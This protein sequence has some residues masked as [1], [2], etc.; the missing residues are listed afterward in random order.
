MKKTSLL[1]AISALLYGTSNVYALEIDD[2]L[3]DDQILE[4]IDKLPDVP[5]STEPQ[6]AED[7]GITGSVAGTQGLDPAQPPLL[8][9]VAVDSSN[10]VYKPMM[11]PDTSSFQVNGNTMAEFPVTVNGGPTV[12]WKAIAST[13]GGKAKYLVAVGK[14]WILVQKDDTWYK[15]NPWRLFTTV[16]ITSIVLKPLLRKT[17]NDPVGQ[18]RV[19]AFDVGG[20]RPTGGSVTGLEHT[21]GAARGQFIIRSDSSPKVAFTATYTDPV[22]VGHTLADDSSPAT[23]LA[24]LTIPLNAKADESNNYRVPTHD[25]YGTLTINFDP[26]I[27]G[28]ATLKDLSFAFV[29]DTDCIKLPVVGAS[30]SS[31]FLTL[32]G[33]GLVYVKETNQ[34]GSYSLMP[35]PFEVEKDGVNTFDVS[36]LIS[37]LQANHCYSLVNEGSLNKN[38]PLEVNG[39]DLPGDKYCK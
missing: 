24:G 27:E 22:F 21:I 10:P 20:K 37:T 39:K 3:T 33:E 15:A 17:A 28:T 23:A 30:V 1:L 8:P 32:F 12:W 26:A 38:I 4:I 18:K 13:T 29:A 25:L 9:N 16:P 36:D 34:S 5:G 11:C 19:Y 31:N 2:T 7:A 35:T 6:E 14:G